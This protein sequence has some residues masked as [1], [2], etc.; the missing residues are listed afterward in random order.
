V[1]SIYTIDRLIPVVRFGLRDFDPRGA[2]HYWDFAHALLGWL[3]TIAVVA[4]LN[5][6]VRRE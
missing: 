1:A 2:A 5:A 4:D 3:V 6:A